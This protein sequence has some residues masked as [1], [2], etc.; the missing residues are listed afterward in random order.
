MKMLSKLLKI[1][2]AILLAISVA[3]CTQEPARIVLN[4]T[5]NSTS[6]NSNNPFKV[7]IKN[8]DTIYKLAKRYGVG[9]RDIIE[10]NRLRPPYSITPGTQLRLPQARFHQV[11]K[12]DT[13]YAI[14]RSY[15]VEISSLVRENKIPHPYVIQTSQRLKIPSGNSYTAENDLAD[16][17]T[18]YK[19]A[20]IEPE[21][22]P[23]RK[24]SYSRNVSNS[25]NLKPLKAP[26]IILPN[27][28]SNID[29]N[30]PTP[31]FRVSANNP[32]PSLKPGSKHAS[33][34]YKQ[35]Y[36]KSA[37]TPNVPR[38]Q[39]SRGFAWPVRGKVISR[40]GP[41]KGGLYNDGI[42]I[43]SS[44]GTNIMSA[45]D[46]EVVYS[47]NE[48]RGYGNLVLIKHRGG[49]LTAYAHT[50]EIKVSKGDKVRQGQVIATM[51]NTGHV[52]TPQ[53]HFSIRKGR[54]AINPSDYLS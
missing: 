28:I 31:N 9:T 2:L 1:S 37:Y 40:F 34:A 48:L 45:A 7:T 46:G 15:G 4:G 53:L 30:A 29:P 8:G 26:K 24:P 36:V 11:A 49:Y 35:K 20:S 50:K 16:S 18:D 54:K 42:N 12:G 5:T 33:S 43:S 27:E 13:I 32:T 47:G 52:K 25:S 22:K 17:D 14:S 21:F 39:A 10:L 6:V 23:T 3:G 51:G 38:P 41:K 19:T 44:D